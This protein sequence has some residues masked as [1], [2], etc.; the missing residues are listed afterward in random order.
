M[1]KP[2]Y[3]QR[4]AIAEKSFQESLNWHLFK[5]IKFWWKNRVA[6]AEIDSLQGASAL[7]RNKGLIWL[8]GKVREQADRIWV[9]VYAPKE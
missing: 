5:T 8:S 1:K 7:L 2:T 6:L 9:D 3:K 4:K